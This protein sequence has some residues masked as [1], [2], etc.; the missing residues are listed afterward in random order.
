MVSLPV[1]NL[2]TIQ[3]FLEKRVTNTGTIVYQWYIDGVVVDGTFD[4]QTISGSQTSELTVTNLNPV[5]NGKTAV[6]YIVCPIYIN[7]QLQ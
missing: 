5:D 7:H 1:L 2:N 3:Q 6:L 4:E